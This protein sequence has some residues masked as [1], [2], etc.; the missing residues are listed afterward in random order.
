[1]TRFRSDRE[2]NRSCDS[3]TT[4]WGREIDRWNAMVDGTVDGY[5]G[6]LLHRHLWALNDKVSRIVGR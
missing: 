4:K 1:M 3:N 5:D 6:V 2:L